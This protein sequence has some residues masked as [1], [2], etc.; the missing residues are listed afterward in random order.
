M[1]IEII[2]NITVGLIFVGMILAA[3]IADHYSGGSD[4]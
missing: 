1:A 2:Q 3:H 4:S